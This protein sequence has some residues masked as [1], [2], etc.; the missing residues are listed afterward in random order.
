[1]I[2]SPA[3]RWRSLHRALADPLRIRLLEL[4][5]GQP[6]SAKELADLV[7]LPAD[8]L[9]HHLAQLEDGGLIKVAEYRKLQRGKVERIYA[10][11]VIEPPREEASAVELAQ[12]L[13][14]ML[15]ATR[16]DISSAAI[17]R[18]AGERREIELMR[19]VVRLN[20]QHL[21][22]LR[23]R[24]AELIVQASDH[25]DD[26]GTFTTVLWT[27]VDRQ[28]RGPCRPDPAPSALGERRGWR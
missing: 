10:P 15:E 16:A 1:M 28:H 21:A 25:P 4:L 19:S 27:V 9:Y 5:A 23:T 20:E 12:F 6:R 18:E 3:R 7:E 22:E 26:D 8:R 13:S 14:A 17:G 2:K 24:L 11:A